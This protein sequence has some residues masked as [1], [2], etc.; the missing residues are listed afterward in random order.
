MQ[1]NEEAV[2]AFQRLLQWT[3]NNW[4]FPFR[5][6]EKLSL[7]GKFV[8]LVA[9]NTI[10]QMLSSN[11]REQFPSKQTVAFD[12]MIFRFRIESFVAAA[13]KINSQFQGGVDDAFIQICLDV[14]REGM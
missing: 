7:H 9:T 10:F 3:N 4:E 14:L 12:Q 8:Q 2:F 5:G 1:Q 11:I 6:K 13:E